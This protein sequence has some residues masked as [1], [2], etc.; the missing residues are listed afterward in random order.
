[1]RN[2]NRPDFARARQEVIG[3]V[4]VSLRQEVLREHGRAQAKPDD[5]EIDYLITP[6]L[7]GTGDLRNLWPEPY[8]T[9]AWDT[10]VK[11]ALEERLHESVCGGQ[12]DLPTAQ[13]DIAS[14]CIA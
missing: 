3:N 8:Y 2:S 13:H 6:G 1:M 12:V 11:D 5:C 9:P 7:G 4:S 14:D 10:R